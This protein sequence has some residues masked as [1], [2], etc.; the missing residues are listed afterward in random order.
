MDELRIQLIATIR[1]LALKRKMEKFVFLYSKFLKAVLKIQT[2]ARTY[3]AKK[4]F[5]KV[6]SK[7]TAPKLRAPAL[8]SH[9]LQLFS[10]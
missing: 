1:G 3:I 8:S 6:T 2:T 9:S 10:V 4:S 5:L 7:N